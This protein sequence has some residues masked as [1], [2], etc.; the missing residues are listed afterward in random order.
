VRE[1][2][3][4]SVYNMALAWN[5]GRCRVILKKCEPQKVRDY[6]QRVENLYLDR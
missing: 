3:E 5:G 2:L 1:R 4:P 6:A